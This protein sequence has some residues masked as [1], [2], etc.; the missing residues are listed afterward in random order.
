MKTSSAMLGIGKFLWV[1]FLIPDLCIWSICGEESCEVQ[2]YIKRNSVHSVASGDPFELKCPVKYCNIRPNVTWCKLNRSNCQPLVDGFHLHTSWREGVNI[3]D[4]ILHF[5]PVLPSDN[6]SYRCQSKFSVGIIESHS[7]TIYVT[8]TSPELKPSAC[9]F[10]QIQNKSERPLMSATSTAGPAS[11]EEKASQPWLLYGLMVLGG[12]PLLS[13]ICF[14][15]LCCL[16]E[17][18]GKQEK[19]TDTDRAGR[20]INLVDAPQLISSEQ[21]KAGPRKKSQTVPAE[22]GIYDNDPW[23]RLQERAEVYSNSCL[24]ENKQGIVYASLNHSFF[25]MNPKQ[26]RNEKEAPTEYASICVRS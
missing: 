8:G 26:T 17:H 16:R 14:C 1:L 7:T 22:T 24:E 11:K 4:F 21:A 15:L 25:G 10:D 2:L 19:P 6:G 13:I 23:F 9:V 20:E 3:S 18:Q 5:E 12:L